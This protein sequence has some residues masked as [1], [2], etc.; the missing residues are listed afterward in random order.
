MFFVLGL[1][2]FVLLSLSGWSVV[3]LVGCFGSDVLLVFWLVSTNMKERLTNFSTNGQSIAQNN[4]P[5]ILCFG[6]LR[7]SGLSRSW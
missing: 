2:I 5:E 4:Y 7:S 1:S 6:E 3:L